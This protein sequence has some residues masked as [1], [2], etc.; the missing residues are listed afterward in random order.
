[1]KTP[2]LVVSQ[3]VSFFLCLATVLPPAAA[4]H[5]RSP[6]GRLREIKDQ[7]S[8]EESSNV[9]PT[10]WQDNIKHLS[11]ALSKAVHISDSSQI[12]SSSKTIP[13]SLPA[14][15]SSPLRMARSSSLDARMRTP[16][17]SS[18][19]TPSPLRS[20]RGRSSRLTREK[21][22][23]SPPSKGKEV[24]T[25]DLAASSPQAG[26][27]RAQSF[28]SR[29]KSPPFL[30]AQRYKGKQQQLQRARVHNKQ[31]AAS[32]DKRLRMT[33]DR[34]RDRN[35]ARTRLLSK[36]RSQPLIPVLVFGR[37]IAQEQ[38]VQAGSSSSQ[39]QSATSEANVEMHQTFGDIQESMKGRK[40]K[41]KAQ[42]GIRLPSRSFKKK[43]S[44]VREI[45]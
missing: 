33:Q 42:M 7:A 17:P 6:A 1:M 41:G 34:Q 20:P 28:F 45:N 9:S 5:S 19:G 23:V 2:L 11:S 40:A 26:F 16:S 35:E 22:S 38:Q 25:T 29:A 4:V 44:I 13:S 10:L 31:S 39:A 21:S 14:A 43:A 32:I 15:R 18:R 12:A 8:Q 36:S 37:D 24:M 3:V 27:S 30:I